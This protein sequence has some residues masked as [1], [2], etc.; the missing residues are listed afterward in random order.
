MSLV[1][2]IILIIR[3]SQRSCLPFCLLCTCIL[4]FQIG[5]NVINGLCVCVFGKSLNHCERSLFQI[6]LVFF[7]S[8]HSLVVNQN[9]IRESLQNPFMLQSLQRG[10]SIYWVPIETLVY[11]IDELCVLTLPEHVLKGFRVWQSASSS[12]IRD[13]DRIEL[14]FF[15]EKIPS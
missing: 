15:K 2:R 7:A 6:H 11:E 5:Y 3:L 10:H 12:R 13:N 1:T 14:V 4:L 9:L 8:K